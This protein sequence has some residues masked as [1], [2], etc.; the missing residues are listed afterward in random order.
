MKQP[1]DEDKQRFQSAMQELHGGDPKE[2]IRL[3]E[4]VRASWQ[5][6]PDIL[7]LEGLAYGK[8][9]LPVEV[10]RVSELALQLAPEHF[11]ALC[12]LANTQMLVG[13]TEGALDNYE[14]ALKSKPDA[15][16]VLDNYGRALGMLGRRDEAI[17]HYRKALAYQ[18]NYAPA[19]A[20]LGRAYS[21]AG[22]PGAAWNE[23]QLALQ[24]D[25]DDYQTHLGIA[26]LHTGKGGLTDAE[27]HYK[28]AIRIEKHGY[29]AYLGLA[30]VYLYDGKFDDALE[31]LRQ[32][33]ECGPG[34]GPVV[35]ACRAD[36]LE[37]MGRI[38]EAYQ[39][40]TELSEQSQMTPL[41]VGVYSRVCRKYADCDTDKALELID[42]SA[43][44][45]ATESAQK[46]NLMY[47]AGALLDKLGR[48]DEAFDYFR[49][50]NEELKVPLNRDYRKMHASLIEF[51]SKENMANLPR[52]RANSERPIFVLGMPRSGTTLTETI[53]ATHPD[54]FGA[55]ELHDI[56]K[57]VMKLGITDSDDMDAFTQQVGGLDENRMTE[58]ADEYLAK[59]QDV[60]SEARF[61]IDKM[62]HNF[63]YVGLIALLFPGARII[64]CRRNPMDTCLSIYFQN[65]I[66]SHDYAT[67]L[68]NIGTFYKEYDRL[69]RHWEEVIDIPM[70]IV[71]YEDMIEDQE[72]MTRK[73]LEFCGLEWDD[74]LM[75]FHESER[76]VTTASY[77]QVRQPIYKTSKAR[78]KNY[79]RHLGPLKDALPVHCVLGIEGIDLVG[80]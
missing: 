32:A 7:Y 71:Q 65:F 55:G 30:S 57:L 59:L 33:D 42:M 36:C 5:D 78:W 67:E 28:E 12:N 17:A 74:S 39:I 44:A 16:E 1:S 38:D 10:K 69:M 45:S 41:A 19:H 76:L 26:G 50:A 53:M 75:N 3:F 61:V 77:D 51:F 31:L 66:W 20:A 9:A 35:S 21:E 23:F 27:H 34:G 40:L 72:G 2:A 47:A 6:D 14:K 52:S 24:F 29:Q 56:K 18:P 4:K 58:L 15:P 37:R 54:V 25:P 80:D 60:D 8:L 49:R 46:Q 79:A 13:D 62:P 64:H 70:M 43:G 73:L 63:Q 11:G 22:D 68:A 48:Y